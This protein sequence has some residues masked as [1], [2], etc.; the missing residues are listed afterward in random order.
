M[1][2]PDVWYQGEADSA[3]VASGGYSIAMCQLLHGGETSLAAE[4]SMPLAPPGA[5]TRIGM[6]CLFAILMRRNGLIQVTWC[7][8]LF[9]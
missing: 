8:G 4:Y 7:F 9:A 3:E 1:V 5:L 2:V 6:H